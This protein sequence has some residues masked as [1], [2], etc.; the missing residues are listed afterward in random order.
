[1]ATLI[2]YMNG[3]DTFYDRLET[4]FGDGTNDTSGVL[5]DATNEV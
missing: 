1:M 2:E 5:F 4:M 3:T